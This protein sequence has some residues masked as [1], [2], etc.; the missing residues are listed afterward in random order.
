MLV[1]A[2]EEEWD[3]ID[4]DA[5]GSMDGDSKSERRKAAQAVRDNNNKDKEI[6]E[7]T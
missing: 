1:S 7:I 4:R 2:I 3:K 6:T 5:S